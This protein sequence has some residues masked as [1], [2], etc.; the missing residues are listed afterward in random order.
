M[1]LYSSNAK[2]NYIFRRRL[3]NKSLRWSNSYYVLLSVGK[4]ERHRL[5][6][7]CC[8]HNIRPSNELDNVK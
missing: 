5:I 7:L 1:Q 6:F 3:E 4:L 8:S 2:Q